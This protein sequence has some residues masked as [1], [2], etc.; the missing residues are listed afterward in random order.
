MNFINLYSLGRE[1]N[2]ETLIRKG[3]NVNAVDDIGQTPI[4]VAAEQGNL[5]IPKI[6]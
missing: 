3:S 4:Y 5:K 2:A 6:L 1:T